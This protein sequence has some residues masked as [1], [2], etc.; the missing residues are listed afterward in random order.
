MDN[1]LTDAQNNEKAPV[2]ETYTAAGFWMRFWAYLIDMFAVGSLHSI[3]LGFTSFFVDLGEL[4]IGIYSIA[5]ALTA[6]LTFSY[7][8]LL[9][10]LYGQTL[11]KMIMGIKVLSEREAGMSWLNVIMR[12]LV[13]RYLHKAVVM[14]NALY[15]VAAFHPQKRGLHDM[16]GETYVVLVPRENSQKIRLSS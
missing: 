8:I 4:T 7:F 12:E 6:F 5:G 2:K 15:L 16:L 1:H 14:L 3:I 13:G 9:T 10:K 11:G